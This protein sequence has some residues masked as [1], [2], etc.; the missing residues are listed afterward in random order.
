MPTIKTRRKTGWIAL[1]FHWTMIFCTLG[2]WYPIYASRRR[3]RITVTHIP[4]G[5]TGPV[6]GQQPYPP[7]GNQPPQQYPPQGWGAARR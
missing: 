7:Q 5:Y 2:L 3:S 4:E 1:T 6:P